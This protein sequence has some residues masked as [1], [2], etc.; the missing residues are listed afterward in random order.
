MAPARMRI[1][2]FNQFF[3]PDMSA[4]SQILT[5]TAQFLA[6]EHEIVVICS[7]NGTKLTNSEADF[8]AGVLA[9]RTQSAGFGHRTWQ[10][11]SSYLSYLAGSLF[12]GLKIKRPEVYV[13]LTTPPVLSIVGSLLS[14]LRGTNH[15]IWEMDVYPDIATDIHYLKPGGLLD[16]VIGWA[17]DW[18]RRRARTIIV[19]GEDM[20]DRLTARGIP[21]SNIKVVENWADGNAI[22]QLPFPDGPLVIYYSGNLGLAHETETIQRVIERLAN[23]RD[24][25]FVFAGGGP[26]RLALEEFCRTQRI[27]NVE[28]RPY[29]KRSELQTSLAEGHLGLVT[30][31]PQTLGSIVPSK[32]YGIMAAGRPL[33]F[34]GP[35]QSTPARHIRRFECGW[36]VPSGNV[37]ELESLLIHLNRNRALLTEAGT[38][39]RQAFESEFDSPIG[40][41]AIKNIIEDA[42]L[43]QPRS[44]QRNA[45]T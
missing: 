21:D 32:I 16:R 10:R 29:S 31:L 45:M 6:K 40:L 34:V 12:W 38:R 1:V 25:R 13:T 24:F 9:I 36:H 28:F 44:V 19:L 15:V 3:W 37:E 42:V 2:L 43:P 8:A 26:R 4:T 17:L 39:A 22:R 18:S 23:H 14:I 7:G 5:D 27:L 20:K 41:T 11:L 30:Q 33:L 35:A